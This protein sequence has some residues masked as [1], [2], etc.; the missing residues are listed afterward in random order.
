MLRKEEGAAIGWI[1]RALAM[2]KPS[3]RNYL[4]RCAPAQI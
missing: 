1:A 3:L 4:Y 2:G